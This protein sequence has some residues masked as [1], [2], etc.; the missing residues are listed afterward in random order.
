MLSCKNS[1]CSS[2]DGCWVHRCSS[3]WQ[4]PGYR[5]KFSQFLAKTVGAPGSASEASTTTL[6]VSSAEVA[7]SGSSPSTTVAIAYR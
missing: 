6:P 4:P 1:T 2:G 3:L 7:S 5:S